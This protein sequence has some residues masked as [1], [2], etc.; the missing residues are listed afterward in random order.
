MA[1][2]ARSPGDGNTILFASPSIVVNPNLYKTMPFDVDKNFVP[3]SSAD[4]AAYIKSEIAKWK[5]V[6]EVGKIPKI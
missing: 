2:A 6:I 3:A 1:A 4:F 5:R